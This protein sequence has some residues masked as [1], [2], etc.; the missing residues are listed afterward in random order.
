[1]A[2]IRLKGFVT[3]MLLV[4]L[5]TT[6]PIATL[7]S[8]TTL[9]LTGTHLLSFAIFTLLL[10][11][12]TL[13]GTFCYSLGLALQ[14]ASDGK[15]ALDRIQTFLMEKVKFAGIGENKTQNQNP[16]SNLAVLNCKTEKKNLRAVQLVSY[17]QSG[18]QTGI[19]DFP[20]EIT[21]K[22]PGLFDTSSVFK[23]PFVSIFEASCSWN[24]EIFSNTLSDI[25]LDVLNGN[26]LAITGAV[27]SG[28]SSLL[29]AILG[30]LPQHRGSI[31]Y[32][33]SMAYVLQIPWVFSGTIRENILFGLAFSEDRFQQIVH[34]CELTKDLENFA[35]G[36]LTRAARC[37][38]EWR[39]ESTSRFGSCSVF[40]C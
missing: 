4:L 7:V 14:V 8:V 39:S 21:L 38:P 34:I 25:T 24:K 13:Q 32:H 23:E 17:P 22:S 6:I 5:F 29:T 2:I 27:G 36:D 3:S 35:N 1:M 40:R 19:G 9:I 15:V 10:S 11:L 20:S 12:T 26:I 18:L 30:E 16:N 37:Y 28:K 31:S 33:G